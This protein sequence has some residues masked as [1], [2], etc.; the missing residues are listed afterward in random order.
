M[1]EL[2][3]DRGRLEHMRDAIAHVVEFTDGLSFEELANDCIRLHA[4]T[5]N[6]QIIG[7]ASNRLTSEFK[8]AHP[9]VPWRQIE[10]MRHI[11]V[12]DYYQVSKRVIW[13]VVQE[14]IPIL[15]KQIDQLIETFPIEG[16]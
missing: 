6:I 14:D 15:K 11:L 2:V 12:H 10:K 5:Y 8:S 16:L 1:K 9:E 7:E 13:S 3:R 4:T